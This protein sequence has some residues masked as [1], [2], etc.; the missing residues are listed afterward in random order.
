MFEE[1]K[2]AIINSSLSSSVYV[3]ADSMRIKKGDDWYARYSTVIILHKDSKHGCRVFHKQETIRDYGNLKQRL[4]NEAMYAINAAM[5]IIDIIG[6]RKLELHLDINGD[7]KHKSNIAVKE[8]LGYVKGSLGI[9]AVIKP[10]AF[11]ATT[12]ADYLVR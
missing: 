5:Q 4:L 2:N 6:D 12:C 8:A 9:D 7:Q 11:A 3:G 10:K 1:A